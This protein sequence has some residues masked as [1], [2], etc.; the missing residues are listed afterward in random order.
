MPFPTVSIIIPSYNSFRTIEKSINSFKMQNY[1]GSTEIIVIDSSPDLL[2]SDILNTKFPELKYEHSKER[3]YPHGARNIGAKKASGEL[4]IFSDPDIY[5]PPDWVGIMVN[6]YL[7]Y[8]G[9]IVGSLKCYNQSLTKKG[10]HITKFD[11]WLPAE[12][13]REIEISPTANMLISRDLLRSVGYFDRSE[14][15]GDTLLSWRIKD[16]GEKITFIPEA[17]VYHDHTSGLIEFIKERYIRGY[18]FA[19][20]RINRHEYSL[21]KTF[22]MLLVSIFPVRLIKLDLRAGYYSFKAGHFSE[23]MLTQPVIICGIYAW[24][25]GESRAFIHRMTGLGK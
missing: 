13:N 19:M 15:L 3:L 14:F 22:M 1:E 7:T 17:V 4:I 21:F 23:Y 6:N 12:K 9:V 18:L 11:L 10:I 5:A 24:L 2:V 20:L 25:M 16:K 8:S